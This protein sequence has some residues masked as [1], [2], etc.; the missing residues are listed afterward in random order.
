MGHVD[1]MRTLDAQILDRFKV[2]GWTD[3]GTLRHVGTFVD[4]PCTV[5]VEKGL[6]L[7]S[8]DGSRVLIDQTTVE[9]YL[10]QTGTRPV[11]G[12]KFVIGGKTYRVDAIFKSDVS[13]TI[14][15]VT[16]QS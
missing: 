3:E 4:V 11:A 1:F 9:S 10:E 15:I 8:A 5:F 14:N 2:K 6:T 13:R 12:A 7:P 16:E